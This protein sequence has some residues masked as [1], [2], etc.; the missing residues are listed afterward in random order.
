MYDL[1]KRKIGENIHNI[2]T[3]DELFH[4]NTL[5]K[6]RNKNEQCSKCNCIM[7]NQSLK[8][9]PIHTPHPHVHIYTQ[10]AI[11]DSKTENE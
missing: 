3:I 2:Q 10:P 9:A 5:P 8:C 1:V 4:F 11:Q 7:I 6:K